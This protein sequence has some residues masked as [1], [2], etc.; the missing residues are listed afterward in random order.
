[1]EFKTSSPKQIYKL[2]ALDIYMANHAGY[3]AG[4]CFKNIFNGEPVKDI[5]IF[6]K[7]P[8][9]AEFARNFFKSSKEYIFSYENTNC[10]SYRN[11]QTGVRVEL[12]T[13]YFGEPAEMIS[14]FDFSITKFAYF[15]DDET[16]EYEAVYHPDFFEH[17]TL[18]KLVIER[19]ILFP[20]S[21]FNRSLRYTA[22]GY[23][24]CSE[25][26]TNL[27]AAIQGADLSNIGVDL[28]FGL[29]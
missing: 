15:K 20:V 5:D 10:I 12:I 17:L 6:F 28:Y 4:G 23:G 7:T 2:R 1:M 18:R 27:L 11:K 13:A 21:T 29:D 9:N 8:E 24:L 26:K 25:S 16:G 3:I 14:K 22:K 19:N